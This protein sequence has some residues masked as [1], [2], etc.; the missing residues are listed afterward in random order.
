MDWSAGETQK[1]I[2][3]FSQV[4]SSCQKRSTQAGPQREDSGCPLT[5][6]SK[7]WEQL[8]VA[9]SP[10]TTAVI[11]MIIELTLS[12][13]WKKACSLLVCFSND[14]SLRIESTSKVESTTQFA[15]R[16]NFLPNEFKPKRPRLIGTGNRSCP[17]KSESNALHANSANVNLKRKTFC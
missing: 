6:I 3:H 13:V 8:Y 14:F 9:W 1:L 11:M 10:N 15:R 5:T 17:F 4:I 12:H 16:R 7:C 2:S